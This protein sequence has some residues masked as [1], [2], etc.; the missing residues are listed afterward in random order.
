MEDTP[1]DRPEKARLGGP[2]AGDTA[3]SPGASGDGQTSPAGRGREDRV[4]TM[5]ADTHAK[6]MKHSTIQAEVR[7]QGRG[8]VAV[9]TSW[10]ETGVEGSQCERNEMS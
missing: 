3:L 4:K 6:C 2:R 8:E 9:K 5:D 10:G 7:T 1:Q